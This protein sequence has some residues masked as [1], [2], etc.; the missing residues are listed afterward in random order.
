MSQE[1]EEATLPKSEAKDDA[2]LV[3]PLKIRSLEPS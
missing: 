1:R 3:Y 2:Q